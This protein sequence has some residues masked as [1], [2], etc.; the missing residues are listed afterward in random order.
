M[1]NSSNQR[2]LIIGLVILVSLLLLAPY[3]G[4]N[5]PLRRFS[6]D[7]DNTDAHR[8]GT[9]EVEEPVVPAQPKEPVRKVKT[10][11]SE[12]AEDRPTAGDPK[13]SGSGKLSEIEEL[14]K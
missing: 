1:S 6:S 3:L 11:E 8:A 12:V 9:I 7:N 2:S 13:K 4:I 5:S 14:L 10:A